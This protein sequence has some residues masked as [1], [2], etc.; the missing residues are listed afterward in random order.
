MSYYLLDK[1]LNFYQLSN[2]FGNVMSLSYVHN[3][4]YTGLFNFIS[5]VGVNMDK[6]ADSSPLVTL[7]VSLSSAI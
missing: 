1:G 3:A 4:G 6:H 2:Y 5:G 7:S